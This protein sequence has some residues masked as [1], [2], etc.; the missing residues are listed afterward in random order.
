MAETK[1]INSSVLKNRLKALIRTD[2]STVE[3]KNKLLPIIESL[4][5]TQKNT[6][7]TDDVM[8]YLKP[9]VEENLRLNKQLET[10]KNRIQQL[11]QICHDRETEITRLTEYHKDSGLKRDEAVNCLYVIKNISEGRFA[12]QHCTLWFCPVCFA[13]TSNWENYC[14][15]CG[16]KLKREYDDESERIWDTATGRLIPKKT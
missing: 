10:C 12:G 7:T 15:H 1:Y 14:V 4:E 5:E 9:Y 11:E 6:I 8:I 16:Q 3:I 2:R 13:S